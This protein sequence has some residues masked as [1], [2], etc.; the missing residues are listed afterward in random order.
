MENNVDLLES[1]GF[2][3]IDFIW[4]SQFVDIKED[5]KNAIDEYF[6]GVRGY[7]D[8]EDIQYLAETYGLQFVEENFTDSKIFNDKDRENMQ[9]ILDDQD[10]SWVASYLV[11]NDKIEY[12]KDWIPS[13]F[14][15]TLEDYFENIYGKDWYQH[16]ESILID[17]FCKKDNQRRY[18]EAYLNHFSGLEDEIEDCKKAI[19]YMEDALESENIDEQIV[20]LQLGLNTVHHHGYMIEHVIGLPQGAGKVFLDKLSS[21]PK[22]EQWKKELERMF[23]KKLEYIFT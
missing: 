18:Y 15:E 1:M 16:F 14:E 23:G 5:F 21:G 11:D 10:Q 9:P 12:L 17:H 8:Q 3:G 2:D 19:D 13:V 20:A 6:G 22:M 7:I 4:M